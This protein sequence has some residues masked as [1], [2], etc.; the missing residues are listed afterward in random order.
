MPDNEPVSVDDL[1]RKAYD[2]AAEKVRTA[3]LFE[4]YNAP[5][6]PETA[7]DS[8]RAGI[9]R[10]LDEAFG[11]LARERAARSPWRYYVVLPFWR[12]VG[13]WFVPHAQYW[14]F[15]GS[16]FPLSLPEPEAGARFWL[17]VFFALTCVYSVL[18]LAGARRLAR[19]PPPRPRGRVALVGPR[20]PGHRVAL[21]LPLHARK[22]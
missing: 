4:R 20:R 2:S 17:P 22:H 1:P 18:G 5:P 15:E 13:L 14:D 11:Q 3:G 21:G 9:T 6:E 10:G 7:P 16:L 12:A 8:L 19:T